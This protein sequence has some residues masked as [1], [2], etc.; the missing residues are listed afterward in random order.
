MICNISCLIAVTSLVPIIG[1]ERAT[2]IANEALETGETI[3]SLVLKYN[4]VEKELLESI[5]RPEKLIGTQK[6]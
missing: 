6:I 5:I 4:L 3:R 2:Q 1:Y